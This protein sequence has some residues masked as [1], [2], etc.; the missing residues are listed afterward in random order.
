MKPLHIKTPLLRSTPMSLKVGRQIYV[1]MEALQPSGSFKLRGI[2]HLCRRLAKEGAKRFVVTSAGNAGLAVAYAGR[3]LKVPVTVVVWEGVPEIQRSRLQEEG[4]EVVVTGKD[5]I[6]ANEH[7]KGL[8]QEP[9]V[10][11]VP[12]FDHPLI[13]EGH[14]GL[15]REI[16]EDGVKPG[17]IVLSV[18]GGGLLC[19]V[20]EGLRREGWEDVPIFTAETEGTASFAESMRRGKWITLDKIDSIAVSLAAGRVAEQAFKYGQEC[21]IIPNTV[22]DAMALQAVFEFLGDQRVLVEPA[23]GAALAL[24][25]EKI[26]ALMAYENI[27]VIVCGGAGVSLDLLEKWKKGLSI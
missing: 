22:T 6:E 24:V 9:G 13:W 26:P 18:G 21:N 20:V 2:G 16:K 15:I 23:C 5:W 4:A 25:Y 8:A 10:Y 3:Q 1:K 11:Y 12:P 17:A 14:A 27:V 19:G 7:A